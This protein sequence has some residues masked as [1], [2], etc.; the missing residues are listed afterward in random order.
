MDSDTDC[1]SE[2]GDKLNGDWFCTKIGNDVMK[3]FI[4][5]KNGYCA[6]IVIS[7]GKIFI[8]ADSDT[9]INIE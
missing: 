3:L 1:E 5:N 2:C 6:E 9:V 8:A 7:N 4:T